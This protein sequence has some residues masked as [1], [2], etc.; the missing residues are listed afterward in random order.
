MLWQSVGFYMVLFIAGMQG[1]PLDYYEA[2]RIDGVTGCVC[3]S[4]WW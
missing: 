3:H 2:A 4:V 1:I